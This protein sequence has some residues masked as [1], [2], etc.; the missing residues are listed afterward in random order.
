MGLGALGASLVF[1]ATVVSV[2]FL[3]DRETDLL[4]AART[5]MRAVAE[6]PVAMGVWATVI[7]LATAFSMATAMLGFI[8]TIPVIGHASWHAYREIVDTRGIPA[9]E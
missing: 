2:P 9:R 3:L 6:N 1:A 4:T 8:V 7:M 5:S